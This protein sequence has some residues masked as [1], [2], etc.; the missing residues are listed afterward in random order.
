MAPDTAPR[1]ALLCARA[2]VRETD[3]ARPSR[4]KKIRHRFISRFSVVRRVFQ[5]C[6]V[7]PALRRSSGTGSQ[8]LY[9]AEPDALYQKTLYSRGDCTE[10][11]AL[12]ANRL[13]R[14]L[15]MADGAFSL[16][17]TGAPA[18]AARER[19]MKVTVRRRWNTA[20]AQFHDIP[21]EGAPQRCEH[22]DDQPVLTGRRPR[23]PSARKSSGNTSE[24]PEE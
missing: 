8:Q 10:A 18:V 11:R 3:V 12:S 22:R 13:E 2:S 7:G 9:A 23:R 20:V 19:A 17:I 1:P 6:F 15:S 4:N 21:R 24:C 5:R 14:W 16:I